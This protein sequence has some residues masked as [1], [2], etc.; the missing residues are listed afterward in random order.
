MLLLWVWLSA[1]VRLFSRESLQTFSNS[2]K[3]ALYETLKREDLNWRKLNLEVGL[4]VYKNHQLQD[5]KVK[6]L[7]ADDSV[8]QRR[9]KKME[10]VSRHFDHLTGRSC[11]GQQVLTLGLATGEA[12]LP[13]D[14]QIY[15]SK[16]KAQELKKPF[17]D[18]RS[19]VANRYRE[20]QTSKPKILY[21]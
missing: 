16:V 5:S 7:V 11:M 8:K 19:V 10:G 4:Q 14:S 3:D 9:G 1:S 20:A 15:I 12:F 6:A 21:D 18:G 2:K 17:K 13:I